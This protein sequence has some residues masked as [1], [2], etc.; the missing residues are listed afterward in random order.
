M[1]DNIRFNRNILMPCSKALLSFFS[2]YFFCLFSG[3][4]KNAS[5]VDVQVDCDWEVFRIVLM[6]LH[7]NTLVVPSPVTYNLLKKIAHLG[8]YLS[9]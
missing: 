1:K 6:Y 2:P 9:H 8:Q 7:T 3:C 4:Y 5:I